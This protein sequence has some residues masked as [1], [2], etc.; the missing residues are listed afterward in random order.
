LK[1]LL[2]SKTAW[3]VLDFK[4]E[5]LVTGTSTTFPNHLAV[6]LV[7]TTLIFLG[8]SDVALVAATTRLAEPP[9]WTVSE[10]VKTM[11]KSFTGRL[12]ATGYIVGFAIWPCTAYAISAA[13][14]PRSM[15][16]DMK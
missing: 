15:A 11:L 9:F 6:G 2:G 1:Q 8:S 14:K 4:P 7:H 3:S 16:H 13:S 5:E 12:V 10:K